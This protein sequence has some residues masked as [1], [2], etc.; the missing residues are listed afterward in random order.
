M[1]ETIEKRKEVVR[2]SESQLKELVNKYIK[3]GLTITEYCR[4]NKEAAGT[5]VKNL[6]DDGYRMI[7]NGSTAGGKSLDEPTAGGTLDPNSELKSKIKQL[8]DELLEITLKHE[9]AE[10]LE[11]MRSRRNSV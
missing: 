10:L 2:R 3:S 6:E 9:R 8:E 5:L 4:K 1:A 11:A 7:Q